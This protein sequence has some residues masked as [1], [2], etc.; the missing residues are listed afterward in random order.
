[1]RPVKPAQKR[2]S[3]WFAFRLVCAYTQIYLDFL[4]RLELITVDTEEY[5]IWGSAN[6]A[7]QWPHPLCS[8]WHPLGQHLVV[9]VQASLGWQRATG[10][11]TANSA[12]GPLCSV[13]LVQRDHTIIWDLDYC[14]CCIGKVLLQLRHHK[15]TL[16]LELLL[17][18]AHMTLIKRCV[19]GLTFNKQ[20]Q[21]PTSLC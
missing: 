10:P 15:V 4:G 5:D 12:S 9:A 19:M 2:P 6:M 3:H 20:N 16:T 13:N 18:E 1:M 21:I 17:L 8:S 14:I 11:A 7:M